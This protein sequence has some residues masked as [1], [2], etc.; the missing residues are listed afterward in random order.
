MRENIKKY[1]GYMNIGKIRIRYLDTGKGEPLVFLHGLSGRIETWNRQIPFFMKRGY[2]VITLDI[3]PHGESDK[4][5]IVYSPKYLSRIIAALLE[6]LNVK[7][8]IVIG[9]SMGGILT[10]AFSMFYPQKVKVAIVLSAT[11]GPARRP[12]LINVI[13]MGLLVLRGMFKHLYAWIEYGSQYRKIVSS[14]ESKYLMYMAYLSHEGI[15]SMPRIPYYGLLIG[16]VKENLW[17]D[18]KKISSPT[19]VVMGTRD[20]FF[21]FADVLKMARMNPNIYPIIIKGL[22]HNIFAIQDLNMKILQLIKRLEKA[23]FRE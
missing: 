6:K 15:L 20:E 9:H 10:L 21:S 7:R 22:G 14:P 18:V 17:R 4:P 12:R 5:A 13:V 19:A 11:P 16:L 2:R 1:I 3:P 23:G 8:A